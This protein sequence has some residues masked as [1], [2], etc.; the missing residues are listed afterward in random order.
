M[1]RLG[2]YIFAYDHTITAPPTR[3]RNIKY[4]KTGLGIGPNLK[5]LKQII[6]EN[7][8]KQIN[9]DYL[10]VCLIIHF[11]FKGLADMHHEIHP[12]CPYTL[13]YLSNE[14]L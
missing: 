8:H 2:C 3:G 6:E 7:G 9:I 5:T 12:D 1:D 14:V 10:K 11:T 13:R 4:F